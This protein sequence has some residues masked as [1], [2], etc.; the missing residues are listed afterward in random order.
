MSQDRSFKKIARARMTKRGK[1]YA[2]A[3]AIVAERDCEC[4]RLDVCPADRSRCETC[5]ERY[6]QIAYDAPDYRH[7]GSDR[8]CPACWLGVGP[9]DRAELEQDLPTT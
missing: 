6:C 5:G 4:G 9:K 8:Y 1:S 7:L 3:R 2:A